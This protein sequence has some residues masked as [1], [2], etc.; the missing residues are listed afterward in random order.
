M[1]H[2]QA[3]RRVR[4][5]IAVTALTAAGV[6]AGSMAAPL[7]TPALA[8]SGFAVS[9]LAGAGGPVVVDG[10]TQPVYSLAA[11]ITERIWVETTIDTDH[12][13]RR[14]RVVIDIKRPAGPKRVAIILTASPYL[15]CCQKVPK[16][17]VNVARLP[18]ESIGFDH[19]RRSDGGRGTTVQ[20]AAPTL[21]AAEVSARNVAEVSRRYLPRGYAT[22]SAQTIGT[23]DSEGCPTSGDRNETLSV[24]AVVDWLAGR[25]RGFDEAGRSAR[26]TWST[27]KIGMIGVSYDGTLP[28]QVATTGVKGLM[29]IV[30]ISAISS[31][32]DYYRANGL[33]VA[34]EGFQGEDTD[35]LAREVVSDRQKKICEPMLRA[36]ER[37]QDR[38]TGDWSRFWRDRDYRHSANRI[39][40]SVFIVHGLS[41]WN[42]KTQQVEALWDVLA[43]HEVPRKIWLHQG[44]H[45]G[46]LDPAD[47]I[48]PD[49][50]VGTFDDTV[51]RW[52]D[53]WLYGVDNGIEKEP[54]AII[55]RENF[56]Y[57]TYRDWPDGRVTDR[58]Y[59]LTSLGGGNRVQSFVDNG[60]KKTAESLVAAPAKA[61]PNRL[62]YRFKR[63]TRAT[64]I[65]GTVR[66][67]LMLSVDNRRDAN[68]TALLVDYPPDDS[69]IIVSRGWIDPQN[70]LSIRRGAPLVKRKL[71]SLEF[72]MQPQ[73][74]VF[75][76][77]HRIG[78]VIVSTDH[79]Y[80]L[81]PA[82]GT[83]LSLD[84]RT[85]RIT[86]PI[87]G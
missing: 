32:Y 49:G 11:T 51:N 70:R 52:M 1:T 17:P 62:A 29:T 47:Y 55:E 71:Y 50:R 26:A 75:A 20:A 9:G 23:A 2:P 69:P 78:L 7:A 5:F 10:M 82:P 28:V 42:V 30:P 87:V 59:R 36:L 16:H 65:S 63:L 80:T 19:G 18:Q 68:V 58:S 8:A 15:Q 57:R 25:G 81:R 34:P 6:V 43:R 67:D 24:K 37:D 22:V 41:D 85:S 54:R 79:A 74:Y 40:A 35:V 21:S 76:R 73:D 3:H 31:W 38:A 45:G 60:A 44:F 33:V 61:N 13:G 12:D 66:L 56:V 53:H 27:G 72:G 46:P 86:M 4:R 64:R 48:L 84:P 39:R 14:D 83:K 77:G